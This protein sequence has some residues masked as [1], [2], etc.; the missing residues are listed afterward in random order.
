MLRFV[1]G[2]QHEDGEG[3][4]GDHPDA[5]STHHHNDKSKRALSTS[6]SEHATRV[7]TRASTQQAP[8]SDSGPLHKSGG[9]NQLKTRFRARAQE[10]ARLDVEVVRWHCPGSDYTSLTFSCRFQIPTMT[11]TPEKH[12]ERPSPPVR[13]TPSANADTRAMLYLQT[14]YVK[15][16]D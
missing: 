13:S 9:Q 11:S 2:S 3:N 10:S 6:S 5:H 1:S 8:M 15:N 14:S 7:R 16:T 12:M 4:P